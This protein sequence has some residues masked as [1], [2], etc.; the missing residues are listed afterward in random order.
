MTFVNRWI[1]GLVV[2]GLSSAQAADLTV[3]VSGFA[4]EEGQVLVAIYDEADDFLDSKKARK[5]MTF[6]IKEA[7]DGLKLSDL[8]DGSYAVAVIHDENSNDELDTNF[9]GIPKEPIGTSNNV[10]PRFG[11]PKF[12]EARFDLKVS[13]TVE[14]TLFSI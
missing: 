9:I 12:N 7:K 4:K 10:K 3:K 5:S 14:I 11:P 1:L 13:G 6:T 2:I 8:P